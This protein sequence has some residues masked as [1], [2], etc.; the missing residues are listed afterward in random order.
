MILLFSEKDRRDENTTWRNVEKVDQVSATPPPPPFP[1]FGSMS[2]ISSMEFNWSLF[3]TSS[4]A[5]SEIFYLAIKGYPH[6]KTL[7]VI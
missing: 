7:E 2:N 1:H 5:V 4:L 6:P 3:T